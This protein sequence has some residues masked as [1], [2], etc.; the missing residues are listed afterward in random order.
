[1]RPFLTVGK[2]H[3]SLSANDVHTYILALLDVNDEATK[4]NAMR[5]LNNLTQGA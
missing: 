2:V 1:M 3:E 5:T 4:V